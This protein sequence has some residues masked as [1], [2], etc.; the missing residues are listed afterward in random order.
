MG[1]DGTWSGERAEPGGG[2]HPDA[3]WK[4]SIC[5][6]TVRGCF[7]NYALVESVRDI[8]RVFMSS[9]WEYE[10]E[11]VRAGESVTSQV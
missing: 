11:T 2:Q 5:G 8:W 7:V 3:R 10:H 4:M 9:L 1:G 6:N